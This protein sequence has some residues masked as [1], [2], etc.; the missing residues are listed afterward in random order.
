MS[1]SL[2]LYLSLSIYIY[3]YNIP[4]EVLQADDVEV[5]EEEL[6]GL[7]LFLEEVFLGF[8]TLGSTARLVVHECAVARNSAAARGR[9]SAHPA[10]TDKSC[11]PGRGGE[12][13]VD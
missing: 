4:P 12:G 7:R 11:T 5:Q 2:Y 10:N 8:W 6:R 3:I 1:L 13:A 9:S